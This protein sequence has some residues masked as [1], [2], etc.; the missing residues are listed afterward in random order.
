[1]KKYK[2]PVVVINGYDID[3][4]RIMH[5]TGNDE[6]DICIFKANLLSY[7][8]DISSKLNTPELGNRDP[9]SVVYTINSIPNSVYLKVLNAS[10]ELYPINVVSNLISETLRFCNFPH[11][12]Y[13]LTEFISTQIRQQGDTKS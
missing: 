3:K 10:E 12:A 5:Y 7:I 2:S 9:H 8:T 1:M 11:S 4:E 6:M 13:K